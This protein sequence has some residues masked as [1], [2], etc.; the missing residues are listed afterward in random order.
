M[1]PIGMW[2][3]APVQITGALVLF[4]EHFLTK[5]ECI[6][7]FISFHLPLFQL[8][9]EYKKLNSMH[10]VPSFVVDGVTL[11]QSVSNDELC[12]TA[13]SANCSKELPVFG[14]RY[15]LSITWVPRPGF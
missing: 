10:Q 4:V 8:R 6:C 7:A 2:G 14:T 15:P 5:L 12:I 11:T 9:S 13:V 3:Y 1:T